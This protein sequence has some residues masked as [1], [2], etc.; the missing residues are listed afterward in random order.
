MVL[1]GTPI[2][3][4]LLIQVPDAWMV[5]VLTLI[6]S[7]TALWLLT[8]SSTSSADVSPYDGGRDLTPRRRNPRRRGAPTSLRPRA[9]RRLAPQRAGQRA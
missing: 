6:V 1:G 9:P 7:C 2:P 8:R 4:E 3:G 5:I